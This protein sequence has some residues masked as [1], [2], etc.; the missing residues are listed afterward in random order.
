[1]WSMGWQQ[2]ETSGL[3]IICK[4]WWLMQK[5]QGMDVERA[6]HF[7]NVAQTSRLVNGP[8]NFEALRYARKKVS[9]SI[10]ST[11]PNAITYSNLPLQCFVLEASKVLN[12]TSNDNTFLI[13]A[14]CIYVFL[15]L[16]MQRSDKKTG[17]WQ[18]CGVSCLWKSWFSPESAM[19]PL[20][21]LSPM[22]SM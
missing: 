2:L 21:R 12:M 11:E 19:S 9:Q 5:L 14:L 6:A 20:S 1:M 15:Y 16:N 4:V 3:C 13:L 18:T 22:S 10:M 17:S 7:W 8:Q